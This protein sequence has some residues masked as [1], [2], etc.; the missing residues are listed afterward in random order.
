MRQAHFVAA[1][2]VLLA[3]ALLIN[4]RL[5]LA[6]TTAWM[7][8]TKPS[9]PPPSPPPGCQTPISH[10][11]RVALTYSPATDRFEVDFVFDEGGTYEF[12]FQAED[13][14]GLRSQGVAVSVAV[15]RAWLP[16]LGR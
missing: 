7:E 4:T 16:W 8:V 14:G 11:A 9:T 10:A 3:V 2:N 15:G 6:A 5:P 13:A 12:V 1:M